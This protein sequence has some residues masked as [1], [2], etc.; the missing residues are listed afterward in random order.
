MPRKVLTKAYFDSETN[1]DGKHSF[2]HGGELRHHVSEDETAAFMIT[3]AAEK[4]I[5]KLNLNP[6]RDIDIIL[7]NVSVSDQIFTGCGAEVSHQIGANA[8]WIF[9]VSSAGCISFVTM[10]Q[11]A[12]SLMETT[13]A[14]SALICNVQNA[15]G[16]IFGKPVIRNRPESSVPGDGCGVAYF[17]ANNESP[18]LSITQECHGEF[19]CDMRAA[20]LDGKRNYWESGDAPLY[21]DLNEAKIPLILSRGFRLVPEII[22]RAAEQAGISTSSINKLITNQPNPIFLRNW[23]EALELPKGNQIETYEQHGN[24]FGAA[25][26]ISLE[27]AIDS[28]R[29]NQGDYLALGGFSHAGD[30]AAAAIV[31]WQSNENSYYDFS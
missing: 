28:S 5:A 14:K 21:L 3:Q 7:T 13:S 24:L 19:A 17:V 8:N 27:K 18:V 23:R 20:A 26:P 15:G 9:D 4:L 11:L 6:Q 2:F 12:K 29:L 10:M 25:L 16:R 31:H 22:K 1:D 30:F